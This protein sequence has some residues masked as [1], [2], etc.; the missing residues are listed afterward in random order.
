MAPTPVTNPEW[1]ILDRTVKTLSEMAAN[2]NFAASRGEAVFPVNPKAII[3]WKSTSGHPHNNSDGFVN[4][5]MPGILVTTLSVKG[6][7]QG[8]NCADDE[9]IACVVQIV[10]VA[11]G[12]Q[13]SMHPI[14]TYG[15][16]MN[17]IRHKV[18]SEMT[19]FKQDMDPAVADPYLVMAKDR[20]PVDPQRMTVHE[21]SVAM[22]SFVVYVRHHRRSS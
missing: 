19:L 14:R 1:L 20:L 11:A 4:I 18:L 15:D 21:Q 17:R 6:S 8:V 13:A 2:G 9:A 5:I 16:W 3:P 7:T 10:D 22:F 12:P